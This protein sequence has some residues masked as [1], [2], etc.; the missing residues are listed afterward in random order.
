MCYAAWG[1]VITVFVVVSRP[2]ASPLPG[3]KA[4]IAST[5]PLGGGLSSSASLEVAMY[6]FLQ[7]LIEYVDKAH[8]HMMDTGTLYCRPHRTAQNK[9]VLWFKTGCKYSGFKGWSIV[10]MDLSCTDAGTRA[11]GEERPQEQQTKFFGKV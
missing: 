5:V 10:N 2:P 4:V 8:Q 1:N 11:K 7:Q 6:T 3:F 9:T